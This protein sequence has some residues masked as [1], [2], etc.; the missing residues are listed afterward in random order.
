MSGT[1][2]LDDLARGRKEDGWKIKGLHV[3]CIA[4]DALM[5]AMN[6]MKWWG[7]YCRAS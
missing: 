7:V 4:C 1:A 3:M 6:G 5:Q 2:Y